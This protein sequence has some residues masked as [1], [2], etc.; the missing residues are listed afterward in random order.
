MMRDECWSGGVSKVTLLPLVETTPPKIQPRLPAPP[1]GSRTNPH[2]HKLERCPQGNLHGN[3][4]LSLP[5]HFTPETT[6]VMEASQPSEDRC[7]LVLNP[8]PL[9]PDTS[10]HGVSLSSEDSHCKMSLYL[11]IH[12]VTES[13]QP[14][15]DSHCKCPFTSGYIQSRSP[16]NHPKIAAVKRPFT[17][18]YILSRSPANH[19]KIA[20]VKAMLNPLIMWSNKRSY[21]NFSLPDAGWLIDHKSRSTHD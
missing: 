4:A 5:V 11:R 20:A 16:A 17:S 2:H 14:S 21:S 10:S 19:P 8:R 13:S 3:C 7:Q 9:P 1:R 6:S 18:G 15:E 12:P